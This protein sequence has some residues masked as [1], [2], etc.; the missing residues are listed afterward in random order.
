M[1]RILVTGP[2]GFV[3]CTLCKALLAKGFAVLGAQWQPAPLPDGCESVVVGDIGAETDWSA[4]LAD[5]DAVVHLAA[6]VHIMKDTA[7]D[8]LDAFRSVNVAGTRRLAEAA[9][10]AGVRRFILMSTIK[11][12][13]ERTGGG[14]ETEIDMLTQRRKD[15][16][17]YNAEENSA[18]NKNLGGLGGFSE[19]GVRLCSRF[20]EGDA[21]ASEDAYGISKWEAECALREVAGEMERVVLRAPLIYRPGVKGNMLSLMKLAATGPAAAAG[22]GSESAESAVCGESG[23]FHYPLH[24]APGRGE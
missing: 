9:A 4:A 18:E 2:D 1:K 10:K 5:V 14:G 8:P 12:N 17:A 11:V 16:K 19:A 21:A 3:G 15:A 7:E 22:G 6:R 13:G 24:R 23:G 20:T